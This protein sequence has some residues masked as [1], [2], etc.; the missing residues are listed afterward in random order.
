MLLPK[1]RFLKVFNLEQPDRVPIFFLEQTARYIPEVNDRLCKENFLKIAK[2]PEKAAELTLA[3]YQRLNVDAIIPF[4]DAVMLVEA[5][6][7]KIRWDTPPFIRNREPAV[8]DPVRNME[9]VRNLKAPDTEKDMSFKLKQIKLLF[10]V[11]GEEIPIFA[12]MPAPFTVSAWIRGIAQLKRDFRENPEIVYALQERIV[13]FLP[14]HVEAQTKVGASV[15]IIYDWAVGYGSEQTLTLQQYREFVLTFEQRLFN[16]LRKRKIPSILWIPHSHQILDGMI[17]SKANIISI[18]TDTDLAEAKKK[19]EGKAGLY[20]N[21]DP[22]VLHETPP[23]IES[24]VKDCIRKGA[25][26]GGYIFSTGERVVRA[27]LENVLLMVKSAKKHGEY[28][29][30]SQN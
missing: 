29:I 9:D 21:L 10:D 14:E 23:K 18:D 19:A 2:D 16:Q 11:V 15:A 4:S 13:D 6:G 17:E 7:L 3:A 25:P 27:P 30:D 28:P 8:K 24:A 20:G 12:S 5:M 26:G 1:E 22:Q